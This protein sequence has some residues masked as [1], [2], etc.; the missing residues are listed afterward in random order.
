MRNGNSVFWKM[1]DAIGIS[2]G[3]ESSKGTNMSLE[4]LMTKEKSRCIPSLSLLRTFNILCNFVHKRFPKGYRKV[5][6]LSAKNNLLMAV[7]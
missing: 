5:T 6:G 4:L 3:S 1:G 7:F 2:K